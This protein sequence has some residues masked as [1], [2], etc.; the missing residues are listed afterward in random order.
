MV[1]PKPMGD[2][3]GQASFQ[4]ARGWGSVELK[5]VEGTAMSPMLR[6]GISISGSSAHETIEHNFS[7][8]TVAGPKANGSFFNFAAAVDPASSSFTVSLK[9]LPNGG[10]LIDLEASAV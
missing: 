2:K 4:K 3:K 1:K 6:F 10:Q 7:N 8:S 5:L 9:V